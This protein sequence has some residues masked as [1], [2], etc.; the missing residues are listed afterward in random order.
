MSSTVTYKGSTIAS[1]SNNTKK[2]NTSGKYMEDDVTI[3]DVSQATPV[4]ET[5][6]KS[7]TPTETAQSETITAGA[8]YDGISE[9][10]VSV[11]AIS[12]SYVGSGI[13]RRSSSDMSA[14]G[15][16]VT[17]P[18]GYYASNGTKSVASGTV[19]APASI[20]GTSATVSTG[21]NTLTLTKTVS[22]TPSVTTAGYISSGTAGNSSVSL[23]ASVNTRS[24]SDLTASG[25]TVTAP[26]GYYGSSAS[27]S[28]ASGSVTAPA[29]IS[30]TSASV[31]TGTNTLTLSKTVSV[32]PS[33]TT[34]GYVSSGTAGNSSVS[35]TASVNTRSSSDLTASGATVTAPAGYYGS[36]AS[37]SVASGTEGTPTATKG[38]V[39]NHSVSVTPSVT[40]TAGY[41]SGGTKTGTAVSVTAS[42]LASGNKEITANGTGIDVVGYSTVS[43]DVAGGSGDGS[44]YQDANGYL[45]LDDGPGTHVEIDELQVTQ[46][47]T[48]TASTGHAYSPV[49]VAVSG[50]GGSVEEK[51][52]NFY[53]WDGT[54]LDSYDATE[55]ANVTALPANPSH[56]GL[57]ANG[58]NWTKTEIDNQ[59]TAFPDYPVHVGQT[60]RTTSGATEIDIVLDN[61]NELSPYLG[62]GA[63]NGNVDVD[64][65]DGST[66]GTIVGAG[67]TTCVFQ[68]HVYASTGSYTIKLT[69]STSNTYTVLG[70][71]SALADSYAHILYVTNNY[72]SQDYTYSKTI[73]EI[74]LGPRGTVAS[75]GLSNTGVEK[76][77][78]DYAGNAGDQAYYFCRSL[79]AVVV[80]RV[81]SND[82]G[83]STFRECNALEKALLPGNIVRL[84]QYAFAYCYAL[85]TITVPNTL[86]TYASYVFQSC[87]TLKRGV[88]PA[89]LSITASYTATYLYNTCHSLSRV[90]IKNGVP[91]L[92]YDMF[93]NCKR[94]SDITIPSSVTELGG[95]CFQNCSSL[96]KITIPATVTSIGTRCFYGCQNMAE[97]HVLAT[98]PPTL[99]TYGMYYGGTIYVPYSSD[100]SILE[101]YQT[102]SNWSVYASYMQEEPQ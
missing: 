62:I 7:Y 8:G 11:G 23:T 41:I 20:S 29:S 84:N 73:K 69:P 59:L 92:T 6:T 91:S 79:R 102:A 96:K 5:V 39:S 32:T 90:D 99:G 57:T 9:V 75:Y 81:S 45:V 50:G 87:Y 78:I 94:L 14:S 24:S 15:A 100:H 42:E 38:T 74:R 64:W 66:H 60:Y 12:S 35:L 52:V 65:G 83:N 1:V 25:A 19:T 55:W 53:D 72:G 67:S 43:V 61:T 21:T 33:V 17:A 89:G 95:Y 28:V 30:A 3:T 58:W 44:V 54:L 49:V 47:G 56:T 2:L 93:Y 101:A 63:V 46:N 48:Y 77:L 82:I 40:N 51:L 10:D 68:N 36:S 13:T 76:L 22:V 86:V 97:A 85:K 26:A 18:A 98:T 4:L 71:A 27:K 34:A 80:P 88:L 16:T 31:S 37:K 70:A